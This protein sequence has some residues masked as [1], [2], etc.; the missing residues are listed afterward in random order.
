MK[1]LF[2]GDPHITPDSVEEGERLMDFVEGIAKENA[3]DKVVI[4][5]DLHH[6]HAA[7]RV[8][9]MEFWCRR[10]KR[11]SMKFNNTPKDRNVILLVGNHDMPGNAFAPK[12]MHALLPYKEFCK[13]V[14]EASSFDDMSYMAYYHN[15][16]EFLKDA[17]S[18]AEDSDILVCHQTFVGARFENSFPAPDG[19]DIDKIKQ[20]LVVSGH[21]HMPQILG[22]GKVV[23]VG[24]PRWLTLSDA[25]QDRG[26]NILDTE[27]KTFHFFS[28]KDVCSPI[29]HE[30]VTPLNH[31]EFL[32]KSFPENARLHAT[33]KGS[34]NWAK[35]LELDIKF[36]TRFVYIDEKEIVVKESEGLSTSLKKYIESKDW[37]VPKEMLWKT[38]ANRVAW[39]TQT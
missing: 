31:E 30:E 16:D 15:P 34:R 11:L 26:I 20:S 9:V 24:C 27:S 2:V 39:L 10:L 8:E 19:A 38:I 7:V 4:M 21:I 1:Y 12:D 17:E 36:K 6:T 28:T 5:G 18:L 3:V 37:D 29:I 32:K 33:F 13:V 25:N 35:S 22:N 23:Y 14:Q